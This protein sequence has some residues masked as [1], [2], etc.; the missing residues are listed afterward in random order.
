MLA[1]EVKEEDVLS[2]ELISTAQILATQEQMN[3]LF[4]TAKVM[5]EH[6]QKVSTDVQNYI[7]YAKNSTIIDPDKL[8]HS[9]VKLP[10]AI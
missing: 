9:K 3:N 5:T 8:D 2:E 7:Q 1:A 6:M 4:D 10:Q